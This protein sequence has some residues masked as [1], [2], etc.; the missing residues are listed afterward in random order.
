MKYA[1][2]KGTGLFVSNLSLGMM[3]MSSYL[4]EEKVVEIVK[5]ALL[6]GINVIDTAEVYDN[7]EKILSKIIGTYSRE[8]III[9]SKVFGRPVSNNINGCGLTRKH[10]CAAIDKTLKNLNTDY[11]DIYYL[12]GMDEFTPIEETL[13]TMDMLVRSGKIR[14]YGMSNFTSW[15]IVEVLWKCNDLKL[16]KPVVAQNIYNIVTRDIENELIPCLNH[17]DIGLMIYNILAGGLLVGKYNDGID[18]DTRFAREKTYRER[19]WNQQNIN[20]IKRIDAFSKKYGMNIKDVSIK[21][22]VGNES[23]DS[24][25]I[26]VSSIDQLKEIINLSAYTDLPN[27]L[28]EKCDN[29]WLNL[30]GKRQFYGRYFRRQL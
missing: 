24:C 7:S 30:S 22:C 2:L 8:S 23:I 17:F 27:E 21:K 4:P 25:I 14:Y 12:H 10:I 19:Y 6:E 11:V 15:K 28:V 26:G 3:E 9:S 16:I 13:Q 29:E 5:Y 20:A 18:C 1:R